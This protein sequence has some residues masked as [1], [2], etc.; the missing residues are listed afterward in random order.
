VQTIPGRAGNLNRHSHETDSLFP[1]LVRRRNPLPP[2]VA[3][4]RNVA[5]SE[6][7]HVHISACSKTWNKKTR[8]PIQL[9]SL[10]PI[11]NYPNSTGPPHIHDCPHHLKFKNRSTPTTPHRTT[12]H[13]TTLHRNEPKLATAPVHLR[14]LNLAYNNNYLHGNVL[15][16][17]VSNTRCHLS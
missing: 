15:H 11:P 7:K 10:T 9:T 6:T 12:P 3:L 17:Y 8:A 2:L 13:H 1:S 5:K 16:R 4:A 14:S